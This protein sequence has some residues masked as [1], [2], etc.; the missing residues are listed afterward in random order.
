MSEH[1]Q[2]RSLDLPEQV[3]SRVEARLPRTEFDT[4]EEY[5]GYVLEEVLTY[6]EDESTEGFEA[7]DEAEVQER[8]RSLGYLNE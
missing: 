3:L 6:V 7:A 4:T 5:V 1:E 2:T 8:L